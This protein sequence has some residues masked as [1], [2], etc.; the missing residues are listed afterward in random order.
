MAISIDNLLAMNIAD[1]K[2]GILAEGHTV[3]EELIS[4]LERDPRKGVRQIA[5]IIRK[6]ISINRREEQRLDRLLQ[7]ERELWSK[8][9]RFIAGIDEAGMAP[10]AGPVVAAAVI[11]PQN[12]RLSGLN[13]SK[14]ISSARKRNEMAAQIKQDAV[15]WAAAKAEVEE[16]DRL[17][18]YRAGLLAMR[19]A[20]E[21]LPEKPEFVLVDARNIHDLTC[22]QRAI[23][24][25]DALSASIAAASI[26]AKTTRDAHMKEMD[27]KYPGYGFA[28]HKGYPTLKHM[29]ALKEKGVLP[30][31]R[32]SFAPVRAA[33]GIDPAQVGLFPHP[34]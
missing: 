5:E 7:Y 28:S 30:I 34:P 4:A 19:R 13:D 3:S 20:A 22:P 15:A 21:K 26:I 8:G 14:K 23:V 1:L 27:R 25:G 10:L 31:H 2:T 17:N 33:L 9:V 11:L 18:I 16:I 12:Y 32:K 29:R 24:R 6:R